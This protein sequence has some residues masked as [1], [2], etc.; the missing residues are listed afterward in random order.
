VNRRLARRLRSASAFIG[1]GALV[2]AAVGLLLGLWDAYDYAR[3]AGG[4]P[5][6]PVHWALLRGFAI[7]LLA[8]AWVGFG[9]ELLLPR[10]RWRL[11]FRTLNALRLGGYALGILALL[12]LINA[13]DATARD[14]I[15]P[16]EALWTYLTRGSPLRDIALALGASMLATFALQ[17]RRLHTARE[18][19]GLFTGRYHSPREESRV[20]LYADLAEA[21]ATAEAL[22]H[23]AYSR[24]LVDLFR[25]VSEAV[26]QW[27][28]EVYQH[29]GDA[30]IVS[31]RLDRGFRDDACVHC[32]FDMVAE[33]ES[34]APHY[35]RWYGRVPRLKAGIHAG[36]VMVTWVGEAKREIA[37]H[38]DVLNVTAR[39]LG[40]CRD[41]GV[42]CLIS[43]GVRERLGLAAH[44]AEPRGEVVLRG[45]KA[46]LRL[47]AVEPVGGPH[48]GAEPMPAVDP[49]PGA[50]PAGS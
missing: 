12:F 31:W 37:F 41:A 18:L 25:D 22:G 44:R 26:L 48:V 27:R 10:L 50:A 39:V 8:G 24:L 23:V 4:S 11:G 29:A 47:H 40:L 17:L 6:D 3:S 32:F 46:R 15:P 38:G 33:V 21:T 43:D 36:P 42:R 49:L 28:G 16:E 20:F 7:G 34:R 5:A 45:R 35:L 2:G 30:V 19:W 14:R 1:A 9:E 13:L